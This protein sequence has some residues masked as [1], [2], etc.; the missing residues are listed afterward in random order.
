MFNILHL[1]ESFELNKIVV[2]RNFELKF[3]GDQINCCQGTPR[4]LTSFFFFFFSRSQPRMRI[5]YM[6]IYKYMKMRKRMDIFMEKPK[7]CSGPR[8]LNRLVRGF[9]LTLSFVVVINK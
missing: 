6:N 4:L 9:I 7:T 8:D 1:I 5:I 3:Y 2:D